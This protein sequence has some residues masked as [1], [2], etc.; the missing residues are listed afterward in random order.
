MSGS[1]G[2]LAGCASCKGRCCRDYLVNVS[3]ADVRKIVAVTGLRP[4]DFLYLK[5]RKEDRFRVP[6]SSRRSLPTPGPG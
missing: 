4:T 3:V 6:A 5:E 2:N 1:G